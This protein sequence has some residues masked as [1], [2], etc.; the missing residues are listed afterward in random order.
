MTS[1]ATRALLHSG[2]FG[3]EVLGDDRRTIQAVA[4]A[5]G[6]SWTERLRDTLA[7]PVTLILERSRTPFD[8]SS[9]W[10]VTRGAWSDGHQVVFDDAGGSGFAQAWSLDGDHLE[11]RS[12]W[13]PSPQAAV[14]AKVLPARFRALRGQVLLHYPVLWRAMLADRSPLH[15]SAIDVD[16][17]SIVLAGPGGVGKSTLVSRELASGASATC[18]NLAVSDGL[19]VFGIHEALRVPAELATTHAGAKAAH[20]R[21]EQPW[22]G[23]VPCLRPDLIVA[24]RRRGTTASV[25]RIE[26]ESAARVLVAGTYAA[27]ELRRFWTLAAILGMATGRAPVH[28]PVEALAHRL[29]SR[30]PCVELTLDADPGNRLS[31]LLREDLRAIRSGKVLR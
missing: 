11:V 14:A 4:K 30:L 17:V 3:I 26:P 25:R 28:P 31:S 12:R 9:M 8:H 22:A 27:G 10:P 6:E 1:L 19:S 5:S 15:V 18:D 7:P 29:T 16:G 13:L 21:R 23:R 2:G 20:G 24:V